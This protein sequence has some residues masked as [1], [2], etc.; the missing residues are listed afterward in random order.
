M[1]YQLMQCNKMN[2]RVIIIEK[3]VN[4]PSSVFR[5]ITAK[6]APYKVLHVR[7]V[8]LCLDDGGRRREE[9]VLRGN[10]W[11]FQYIKRSAYSSPLKD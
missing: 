3:T 2:S 4:E 8:P 5:N 7:K 1:R 9:G 6:T 10:Q 11:Y